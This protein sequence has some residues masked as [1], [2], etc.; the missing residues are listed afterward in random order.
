MVKIYDFP[1]NKNHVEPLYTLIQQ[2]TNDVIPTG[3]VDG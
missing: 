1:W 3:M 2:R